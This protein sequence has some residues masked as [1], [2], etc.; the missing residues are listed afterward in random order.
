MTEKEKIVKFIETNGWVYSPNIYTDDNG[1]STNIYIKP[2]H[3]EFFISNDVV[4][5]NT[6]SG[7]SFLYSISDNTLSGVLY[8]MIHDELLERNFILPEFK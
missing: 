3:S 2:N 4:M 7:H 8:F 6:V 5:F 1:T